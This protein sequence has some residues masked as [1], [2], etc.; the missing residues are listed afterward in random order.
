MALWDIDTTARTNTLLYYIVT[1][2]ADAETGALLDRVYTRFGVRNIRFDPNGGLYLN[3]RHVKIKGMAN[4]MDFAGL[5]NAVPPAPAGGRPADWHANPDYSLAGNVQRFKVGKLMLM[6]ANAWRCAHNPPNVDFLHAADELGMLVLDENRHF[7]IQPAGW[8]LP[9]GTSGAARDPEN[10]KDWESMILRDRN[11]P[12]V[13]AWSLCNEPECLMENNTASATEGKKYV[14]A[15]KALDPSRPVTGAMSSD[16]GLGLGTAL[17]IQG[18]NYNEGQY[19]PFHLAHPHRPMLATE[20]TNSNEDRGEYGGDRSF[21]S[22]FDTGQEDWWQ[23]QASRPFMI[24]GFAWT[25]FDYKGEAKWPSVNSH[26]GTLDYAG[27]PKDRFYWYEAFWKNTT[28]WPVTRPTLGSLHVFGNLTGSKSTTRAMV[29][30]NA[31]EV[32]LIVVPGPR[33]ANQTNTSLG[34]KAVKYLQH[35]EFHGFEGLVHGDGGTHLVAHGF[36]NSSARSPFVTT[37]WRVP[38]PPVALQ[39]GWDWGTG[40]MQNDGQDVSLPHVQI[41]DDDGLVVAD[42][43]ADRYVSF[44]VE[45]AAKIIGVGNGN[46]HCH[47]P[48]KATGRTTFH[49]LARVVVQS[50]KN[51]TC[52]PGPTGTCFYA[53]HASAQG[54]RPASYVSSAAP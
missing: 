5:G 22:S 41:V 19:D 2:V 42:G 10:L 36:E 16:W 26:F 29:F 1:D 25:G 6:G 24:G 40:G 21:V 38:G 8:I 3:G 54:L 30:T 18:F 49:G 33:A 28:A 46:P 11:H 20:T 43:S 15:A 14:A 48:D 35:T 4:H 34:R 23:Q 47:E 52:N 13:I 44:T 12:S 50:K 37:E 27:F 45:G 9:D 17:D 32:E 53:L 39:I 7:G 31:A 51:E